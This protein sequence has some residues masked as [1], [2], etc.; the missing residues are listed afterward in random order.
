MSLRRQHTW[1]ILSDIFL[2]NRTAIK[3]QEQWVQSQKSR[4]KRTSCQSWNRRSSQ[5]ESPEFAWVCSNKQLTPLKAKQWVPPSLTDWGET[6]L[7]LNGIHTWLYKTQSAASW[8]DITRTIHPRTKMQQEIHRASLKQGRNK[9]DEQEENS[10]LDK[11]AFSDWRQLR[12]FPVSATPLGR[13]GRPGNSQV[14][15]LLLLRASRSCSAQVCIVRSSQARAVG[16]Y[17]DNVTPNLLQ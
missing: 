8:N 12:V 14:Q 11:G 4:N 16:T 3:L 6:V 15:T 10:S 5:Q 2:K 13:K 9:E 17:S 1:A 7:C